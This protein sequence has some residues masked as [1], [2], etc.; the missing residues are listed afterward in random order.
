MEPTQQVNR[1]AKKTIECMPT[2]FIYLFNFLTIYVLASLVGIDVLFLCRLTYDA[3]LTEPTNLKMMRVAKD[4][5]QSH[6]DVWKPWQVC[7]S[8]LSI[9][10]PAPSGLLTSPLHLH[11]RLKQAKLLRQGEIVLSHSQGGASLRSA[12]ESRLWE[13]ERVDSVLFGGSVYSY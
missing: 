11:N 2:L 8:P 5:E 13:G 6:L 10:S 12:A 9:H 1:I 4:D 3:T 7:L